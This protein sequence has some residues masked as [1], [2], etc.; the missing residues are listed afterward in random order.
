MI[1]KIEHA[2]SL[3]ELAHFSDGKHPEYTR[4]SPP[5]FKTA[6]HGHLFRTLQIEHPLKILDDRLNFFNTYPSPTSLLV[7]PV[8]LNGNDN[9]R[10]SY[11]LEHLNTYNYK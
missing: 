8:T 4:A 5:Y 6:V 3:H 11:R 9:T 10:F 1:C 2:K 7:T